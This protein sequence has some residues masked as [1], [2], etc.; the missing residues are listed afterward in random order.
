MTFR[1]SPAAATSLRTA[2]IAGTRRRSDVALG[3]DESWL[4]SLLRP[5]LIFVLVLCINI[6]LSILLEQYA[7][8]S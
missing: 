7:A 5:L 3:Y 6:A 2:S 4:G 8:G 1:G